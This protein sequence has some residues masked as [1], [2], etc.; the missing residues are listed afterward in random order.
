MAHSVYTHCEYLVSIVGFLNLL[1]A[2]PPPSLL[3]VSWSLPICK[4][5]IPFFIL[6]SLYFALFCTLL[7]I[8]HMR[9][10][11]HYLGLS[12]WFIA[13]NIIFSR[14]IHFL[15]VLNLSFFIAEQYYIVKHRY[16]IFFIHLLIAIVGTYFDSFILPSLGSL[17]LWSIPSL[18]F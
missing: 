15:H 5:S 2:P 11:I 7:C 8:T 16:H 10:T 12:V 18:Q 13:F 3:S 4:T 9:D 6:I 14:S 17:V 1:T